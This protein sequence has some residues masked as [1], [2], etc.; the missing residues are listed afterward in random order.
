MQ[1][2]ESV[3]VSLLIAIGE[4]PMIDHKGRQVATLFLTH[5]MCCKIK[6]DLT[7]LFARLP[8]NWNSIERLLRWNRADVRWNQASALLSRPSKADLIPTHLR[9]VDDRQITY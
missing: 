5:D 8:A 3:S 1:T 6:S 4:A 7:R 9:I 2:I